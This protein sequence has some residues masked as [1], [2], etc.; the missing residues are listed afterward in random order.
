MGSF[1]LGRQTLTFGKPATLT[2]TPTLHFDNVCTFP[3]I[4]V[5]G[6]ISKTQKRMLSTDLFSVETLIQKGI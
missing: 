2:M 4:S 6:P 3:E 5:F 1:G